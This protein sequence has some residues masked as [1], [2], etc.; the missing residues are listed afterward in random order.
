[1]NL[2]DNITWDKKKKTIVLHRIHVIIFGTSECV[3][4]LGKGFADVI[5]FSILTWKTILDFSAGPLQEG[6]LHK[7]EEG[8]TQMW[9]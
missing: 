1:M 9:W 6:T 5:N 8:K 4:L 7:R 3:A 2:H